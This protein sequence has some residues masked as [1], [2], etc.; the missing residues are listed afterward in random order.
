MTAYREGWAKK[1]V[2]P[3]LASNDF[4]FLHT[5]QKSLKNESFS[6]S[7]SEASVYRKQQFEISAEKFDNEEK[8]KKLILSLFLSVLLTVIS[9]LSFWPVVSIG[10]SVL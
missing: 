4:L 6:N 8:F 3:I 7:T 2:P 5:E 10:Q 9:K 1:R